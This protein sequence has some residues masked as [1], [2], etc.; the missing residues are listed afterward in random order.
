M[1]D[2]LTVR[3]VTCEHT[4]AGWPDFVSAAIR[5]GEMGFE[6]SH[7]EI[8]IDGALVGAHADGGVQARA[9]D[10]DKAIW[11]AQVFVT[12]PSTPEQMAIARAF[13]KSELGKPYD[14]QAI[15]EMALGAVTG[16]APNWP[17]SP[18]RICS[19]FV[20]ALLLACGWIKGAPAT[21]RLATPRD[22]AAACA[23][24]APMGQIERQAA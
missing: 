23:A 1:T 10:Y 9:L 7:C 16:E 24:L 2:A 6:F 18:T 22:V 17:D 20:T 3:L 13:I 8:L 14:F 11:A 21:V 12:L 5:G 19:A 4:A 15:K